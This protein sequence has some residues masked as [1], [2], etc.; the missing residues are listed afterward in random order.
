MKK[1]LL[2]FV[3]AALSC[4][5]AMAQVDN[6]LQFV[7]SSGKVLEDG[8]TVK[9]KVE[10]VEIPDAP[11]F[12]YYQVNSGLFIKN[13]SS[14]ALGASLQGEVITMD[15]GAFECCFPSQC[16]N[17]LTMPGLFSTDAG[18]INAGES[19][20]ILTHWTP[21]E[22]GSCTARIQM[23]VYDV[24]F[25]RYGRPTNYTLKG[26]GPSV[27]V[28]FVYDETT[29]DIESVDVEEKAEI[30]SYYSLDGRL[31]SKPQRGINIIR[32]STG[33]T[34]KVFVK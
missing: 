10:Y 4:C 13:N 26:N 6:T 29:S 11:E 21:D 20:T 25:D 1:S 32:Y 22:Y 28:Q 9:G 33:R 18:A 34:S 27:N 23:L 14:E 16:L 31:L 5:G 7:D 30:V 8:A 19:R 2:L 17:P 3:F 24:E 12:S 15:N